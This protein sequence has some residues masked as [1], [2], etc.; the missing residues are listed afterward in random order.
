MG[1]SKWLVAKRILENLKIKTWESPT[2]NI[3]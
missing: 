3:E 2:Q 1:Q